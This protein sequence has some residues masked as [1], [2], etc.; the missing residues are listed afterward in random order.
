L[1]CN[2]RRLEP[3]PNTAVARPLGAISNIQFKIAETRS[4]EKI[5][6]CIIIPLRTHKL[7]ILYKPLRI[8]GSLPALEIIAFNKLKKTVV[9]LGNLRT[10]WQIRLAP[11]TKNH[12]PDTNNSNSSKQHN[13]LHEIITMLKWS[14]P[15]R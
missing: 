14:E 11:H 5:T 12:Q 3:E 1:I 10:L 7:A 4:S 6:R 15:H 8:T 13:N 9:I 2:L